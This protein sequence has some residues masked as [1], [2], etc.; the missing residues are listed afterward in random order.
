MS[1]DL[2]ESKPSLVF[3]SEW[4][5]QLNI[6]KKNIEII[7]KMNNLNLIDP[8][9][10]KI[11]EF[12][13]IIKDDGILLYKL[14]KTISEYLLPI[15]NSISACLKD[16]SREKDLD[17]I[18]S[19]IFNSLIFGRERSLNKK[20]EIQLPT[21][22]L[23]IIFD[24]ILLLSLEQNC[25]YKKFNNEDIEIPIFPKERIKEFLPGNYAKR[26]L[27]TLYK[28]LEYF[29]MHKN[30]DGLFYYFDRDT[31]VQ[32]E[33]LG[34]SYKSNSKWILKFSDS[35]IMK[36]LLAY[37]SINREN[38][39]SEL[40]TLICFYFVGIFYTSIFSN[41]GIVNANAFTNEILFYFIPPLIKLT[42][43]YLGQYNW[44]SKMNFGEKIDRIYTTIYSSIKNTFIKINN[45]NLI[46]IENSLFEKLK[47]QLLSTLLSI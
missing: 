47:H 16:L 36:L 37:I 18:C 46:L 26:E 35:T 40:I 30:E 12:E 29:G 11:R 13:K 19:N 4:K 41:S 39:N 9:F 2:I 20:N 33:F 10:Q 21:R 3:E 28:Y 14:L 34:Y 27:D 45:G 38:L 25:S 1:K 43:F 5:D 22:N 7:Y 42:A 24:I 15:N 17:I 31:L 44:L 6:M 8:F 23:K 32:F